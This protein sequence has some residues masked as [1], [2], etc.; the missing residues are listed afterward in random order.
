[1][2]KAIKE[3]FWPLAVGYFIGSVIGDLLNLYYWK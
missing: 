2:K 1:M 3:I